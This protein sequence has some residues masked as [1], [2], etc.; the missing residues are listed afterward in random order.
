MPTA[1]RARHEARFGWAPEQGEL[2]LVQL[3]ARAEKPGLRMPD[4]QAPQ[5]PL[6][7]P[8]SRRPPIGKKS[9]R[10]FRRS[11]L[12]RKSRI[13]GPCLIE[14]ATSV[15]LVPAGWSATNQGISLRLSQRSD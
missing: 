9:L 11:E 14:E 2:E 4:P 1:F 12:P 6:S 13:S 3:R 7:A 15:T 10:V 8:D 5:G